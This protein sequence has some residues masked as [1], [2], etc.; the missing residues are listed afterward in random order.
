MIEN[1]LRDK[2][3]TFRKNYKNKRNQNDKETDNQNEEIQYSKVEI[4]GMLE[5]LEQKRK[6]GN[7][8]ILRSKFFQKDVENNKRISVATIPDPSIGEKVH[9]NREKAYSKQ[10]FG[11]F[12]DYTPEYMLRTSSNICLKNKPVSRPSFPLNQMALRSK[13]GIDWKTKYYE[14]LERNTFNYLHSSQ[15]TTKECYTANKI[16]NILNLFNKKTHHNFFLSDVNMH[17]NSNSRLKFNGNNNRDYQIKRI[18]NPD[19]SYKTKNLLT[20]KVSSNIKAQVKELKMDENQKGK[21]RDLQTPITTYELTKKNRYFLNNM[22][23]KF[24]LFRKKCSSFSFQNKFSKFFDFIVT[25]NKIKLHNRKDLS[26][27]KYKNLM[28]LFHSNSQK[29]KIN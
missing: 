26:P 8:R 22:R 24:N 9:T 18:S 1:E 28:I 19:Y 23:L 29:N 27:F 21:S 16:S 17:N 4:K 11:M 14:N 10:G 7:N 2:I 15:K 20:R 5:R 12:Q 3:I 6:V 13:Y 25:N